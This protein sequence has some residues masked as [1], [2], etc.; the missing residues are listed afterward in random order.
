EKVQPWT[1]AMYVKFETGFFSI[2]PY[3][4]DS[5]SDFR[6]R[7][8]KEIN[9]WYDISACPMLPNRWIHYVATY[10]A[11]TETAVAF[12]NGEVVG[13]LKDVPTNRFVKNIIIGGDVF[14]PSFEGSICELVIYNET[15]DFDFIAELHQSYVQ[16]PDFRS[17]IL[18]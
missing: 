18:E 17:E 12:V 5:V 8:S 15:K 10:N 2:V 13:M 16:R 1:S 11:K 14:Q 7:D 6:I 3:A 4:W 9:G